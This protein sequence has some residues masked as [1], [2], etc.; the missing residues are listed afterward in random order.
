MK[1]DQ[2]SLAAFEPAA[3]GKIQH[4]GRVVPAGPLVRSLFAGFE[5]QGLQWAVLRNVEGLP[6]YTRNDI[7]LLVSRADLNRACAIV[8][9][10]FAKDGWRVLCIVDK[11]E[12]LGYVLAP[13]G[14]KSQ[15]LL[16]D[17]FLTCR[18]R[19]SRFADEK[20]GL[21]KRR[22]VA[23]NLWAVPV[24]FEAAV[25]AVKEVAQHNHLR[26]KSHKNVQ[27]GATA[28][29]DL[30]LEAVAPF[31]GANLSHQLLSACQGG[32][33][34]ELGALGPALRRSMQRRSPRGIIRAAA[35]AWKELLHHLNPPLSAFVVL[36]GPDGSGKT[37][38]AQGVCERLRDK[39]FKKCA[40]LEFTFGILPE[41]KGIKALARRLFGMKAPPA[42]SVET[43]LHSG[44]HDEH[45]PL[46][47]MVYILYYAFDLFLGRLI[48]RRWR[49]QWGLVVFARYY[50]DYYYLMGYRKA[51]RWFLKA[52][53]VLAPKPDLLLYLDR[54]AEEIYAGKPELVVEEIRHQQEIIRNLIKNRRN[55]QMVDA[56]GGVEATTQ[57]VSDLIL[58]SLCREGIPKQSL[59]AEGEVQSD[60]NF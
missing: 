42:V 26:E 52:V 2:V 50:Y 4:A 37:T 41:L 55:A 18:Y 14:P 20:V 12:Y 47:A 49:G 29:A 31:V 6:D 1:M 25:T 10:V 13:P 15:F 51:P 53:E 35:F 19:S 56:R 30:F 8:R 17:F 36:V 16:I 11:Y 38:I 22:L 59:A 33:W 54:D 5:A 48:L 45:S 24:G 3:P 60:G 57:R 9:D 44:M 58:Q 34:A 7:D 23:E 39:P 32:K 40:R 21:E 28:D 27:N 43:T 46:R